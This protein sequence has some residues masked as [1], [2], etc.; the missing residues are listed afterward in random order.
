[1]FPH[2]SPTDALHERFAQSTAVVSARSLGEPVR[3]SSHPRAQCTT[4][5]FVTQYAVNV[6][7]LD[8]WVLYKR[9]FAQSGRWVIVRQQCRPVREGVGLLV[10]AALAWLTH[11]NMVI[12]SQSL[13]LALIAATILL[14]VLK[15]WLAGRID[16]FDIAIPIA[17]LSLVHFE[18]IVVTPNPAHSTFPFLLLCLT[19][20]SLTYPR[21]E[22]RLAF[23]AMLTIVLLF[24][25]FSIF[26]VPPML[27]LTGC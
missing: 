5:L 6:P 1:M 13:A 4:F 9:L 10:S 23:E 2:F 26:A 3:R 16:C 7:F 18:P 27:V 25:G 14:F 17:R 20:L 12:Q 22:R 24:S 8:Q 15:C 19:G 11:W 21:T